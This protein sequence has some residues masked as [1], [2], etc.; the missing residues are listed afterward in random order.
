MRVNNVTRQSC[1]VGSITGIE[2]SSET[3]LVESCSDATI[4]VTASF[5]IVTARALRRVTLVL[6]PCSESVTLDDCI[7]C[8]I[9]VAAPRVAA[10]GLVSTVLFAA[11]KAPI[12]IGNASSDVRVGPYNVVGDGLLTTTTLHE[13]IG[14]GESSC[15]LDAQ[16]EIGA[17]RA[18]SSADF[19]WR[20]LP[21]PQQ[22]PERLA[23]SPTFA[24]LDA[25][26]LPPVAES[27]FASMRG[28][29]AHRAEMLAQG[30]FVVSAFSIA[31]V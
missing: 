2:L 17:T 21:I 27:L 20:F 13:W 30:K 24:L 14:P 16:T 4:F 23:L 11:A 10:T 7:D 6:A 18:L 12:T 15:R 28:S 31:P 3:L 9:S 8:V 25:P 1:V 5:P 19:Y 26:C 29:G 22:R